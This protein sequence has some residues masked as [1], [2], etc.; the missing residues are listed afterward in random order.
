MVVYHITKTLKG[1]AGQ[2]ALRL[3]SA[4]NGIGVRS[5]L[6]TPE[7]NNP[8][9]A[10]S[11]K[12]VT[13]FSSKVFNKFYRAVLNRVSSAPFHSFFLR[14]LYAYPEGAGAP[15]IIH[16]HG[17]TGWIGCRGLERLLV[18][19]AACLQTTHSAWDLS[20]GCI[21]NAGYTCNAFTDSCQKCPILDSRVNFLTSKEL[22]RKQDFVRR[23]KVQAVAN[24][25][26][27]VD[28][29]TKSAIYR[30]QHPGLIH[31]IIDDAFLEEEQETLHGQLDLDP[32]ARI[33]CLGSR[34]V[35]D[36]FK[37]IPE[38]FK[39]AQAY[40]SDFSKTI[41]LVFGEGNIPA[42]EGLGI[43]CVGLVQDKTYLASLLRTADL[44]VSPS[45]FET[46]GMTLLE[47]QGVGTPVVCFDT[48]G[49]RSAVGPLEDD[50][51]IKLNDWKAMFPTI[52]KKLNEP[53]EPSRK[54][55]RR[56]WVREKFSKAVIAKKQADLYS[57][58]I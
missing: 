2:Y 52:L 18:E 43:K 7:G 4:L 9:G 10:F 3:S 53:E 21:V 42:A 39:Q 22:V 12:R 11:L 23:H 20:G 33:V 57:K 6:F 56:S 30:G 45:Q 49:I 35:T 1:G 13:P 38:F 41:F 46:F 37:G 26:Y 27:M 44:Y 32:D 47:A 5:Y 15:D 28:L 55:M 48:G 34:S 31:P 16:L 29:I 24:S 25:Q 54:E 14:E 36:E 51:L 50:G 40:A 19:G 17:L 8:D 58:L